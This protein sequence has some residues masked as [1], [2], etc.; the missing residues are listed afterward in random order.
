MIGITAIRCQIVI[1]VAVG[2]SDSVG[3]SSIQ[4]DERHS[5][6]IIAASNNRFHFWHKNSRISRESTETVVQFFAHI[7]SVVALLWSVGI[8]TNTIPTN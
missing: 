1:S 3:Q 8:Y 4:N 2:K 5:Y 6:G 7:N